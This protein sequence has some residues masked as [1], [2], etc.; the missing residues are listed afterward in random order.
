MKKHPT[1]FLLI[2][3]ILSFFVFISS[4][5]ADSDE[6]YCLKE[7][8]RYYKKEFVF[9][10]GRVMDSERVDATISEGQGYML[11]KTVAANDPY[12]F[13]LVYGWTKKH[14]QRK[15][16]LFSW[17]WGK[18]KNGKYSVLDY[19]SA[20][21]ADV[22]IA[23]AL[24]LA[25]ERWKN[26]KYLKEA[27]PI[28]KSIWKNET[29]QIGEHRVLMPGFIQTKSEIIEINPSY[30]QPYAFKFFQKYDKK[31]DWN[32]VIDSSYYY[33]MASS[34]KTK[35]GLPPDWFL[36]KKGKIVLEDSKRSDF[37]YDAIRIFL[38]F[39]RDYIRTHDKRDLQI[40]AKSK[41]FIKQW[42]ESKKLY[43]NYKK[44][45][46]LRDLNE[47]TG[48]IMILILP[49]SL[50]DEKTAKEIFKSKIKPYLYN[51]TNWTSRKDYYTKNLLW[52]GCRFYFK[53]SSENIEM[54]KLKKVL[55]ED[56]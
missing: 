20:A 19:N 26:D 39:Y 15:D 55:T 34:A 6:E 36:I 56:N 8:Y 24:V 21:D 1:L 9:S 33:I 46:K 53:N 11:Q 32:N 49:I 22:I 10:D 31:H 40:L 54:D 50:Y 45:G 47:F 29:K 23:F 27:Q 17:L 7:S 4:S 38:S 44:D 16:K 25:N 42:K 30:F 2:M 35:T 12:T 5:N 28:I 13:N 37:S 18:D 41:F 43:T 52:Y 48:S 14:L 51:K 3:F